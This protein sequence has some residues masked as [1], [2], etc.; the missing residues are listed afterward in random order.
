MPNAVQ[1]CGIHC[2]TGQ[3]ELCFF[4]SLTL[5]FFRLVWTLFIFSLNL[6]FFC[7][8]PVFFYPSTC[9]FFHFPSLFFPWRC[10]PW[11]GAVP[12]IAPGSPWDAC[13]IN[14]VPRNALS[15]GNPKKFQDFLEIPEIPGFLENIR[16]SRNF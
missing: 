15:T 2:N 9:L 14:T 11:I 5:F 16:K 8:R 13:H 12:A 7:S 10:F 1:R 6:F 4:C 3:G